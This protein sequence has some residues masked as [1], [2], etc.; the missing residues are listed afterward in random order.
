MLKTITAERNREIV[1]A[2]QKHS[3]L[4]KELDAAKN[5]TVR[6]TTSLKVLLAE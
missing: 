4:L 2:K 5:E 1:F 6:L 3:K